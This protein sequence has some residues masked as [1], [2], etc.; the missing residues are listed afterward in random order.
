MDSEQKQETMNVEVTTGRRVA[1]GVGSAVPFSVLASTV[2]HLGPTGVLVGGIG[3]LVVA[4]FGPDMMDKLRAAL[5]VSS[6][7]SGPVP[8]S[9]GNRIADRL[10]GRN[11]ATG[12]G[13]GETETVVASTVPSAPSARPSPTV[14]REERPHATTDE[15]GTPDDA[16]IILPTAPAFRDMCHLITPMRLV[17]CWTLD[18]PCYGTVQDLLSMAIIG[19]PGRGK[20]TALTYYVAMLLKSG[21]EVHVWDPHGS[22]NDLM[23]IARLHYTDDL[24]D[25]SATLPGLFDELQERRDLYKR[26]KAVKHPLLLLVDELPVI[27]QYASRHNKAIFDLIEKFVLEARKWN[28]YFIG[29]G[30]STDAEILPTRVTENLS[31]RIV[32]FSSD[33]RARMVGLDNETIKTWLPALRPDEAKGKMVFDCAR[34][35]RPILGAIPYLTALDLQQ[36]LGD[37]AAPVGRDAAPHRM[38]EQ[39]TGLASSLRPMRQPLEPTHNE[40]RA[41]HTTSQEVNWDAHYER[42]ER[43]DDAHNDDVRPPVKQTHTTHSDAQSAYRQLNQTQMALFAKAYE[44]TG[45]IDKSLKFCQADN[46]YREHARVI[47]RELGLKKKEG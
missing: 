42:D 40:N 14:M 12:E 1:Y 8:A 46:R 23:G 3:A 34:M 31:S 35:G 15:E 37:D 7:S 27:G 33:R 25:I 17:L 21:A 44:I 10:L 19:L 20:T 11:Y 2:G 5:P 22:L 13:D 43:N 26:T 45:N 32:F 30:Q 47:I 38:R 16:P 28:C 4:G 6:R 36:F 18:G 39:R 9:T 24:D 29:A 41:R